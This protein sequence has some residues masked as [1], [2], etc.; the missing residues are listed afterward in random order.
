MLH[1]HKRLFRVFQQPLEGLLP[2][3]SFQLLKDKVAYHYEE[4]NPP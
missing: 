1:P 3:S 4:G 2:K